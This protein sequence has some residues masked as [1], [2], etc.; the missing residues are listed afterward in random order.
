LNPELLHQGS[1]AKVRKVIFI[2]VNARVRDEKSWDR[3]AKTPRAIPVAVAADA[4]TME[5][6]SSDTLAW[7]GA[8]IDKLRNYPDLKNKVDFYSIDL[9]FD[10]FSEPSQA[11]YFLNLPTTFFLKDHVVDELKTAAHTL[12]YQHPDFKKLMTDLGASPTN[13]ATGREGVVK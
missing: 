11:A 2:C 13:P 5:H 9:S 7:L 6:Y 12:L 4:V 1:L 3:K 8:A 10:Q